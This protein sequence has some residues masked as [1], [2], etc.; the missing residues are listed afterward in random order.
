MNWK[1]LFSFQ[2]GTPDAIS[3]ASFISMLAGILISICAAVSH[4]FFGTVIASEISLAQILLGAG[5][6]AHGA[7]SFSQG[8]GL[9]RMQ[10]PILNNTLVNTGTVQPGQ[11]KPKIVE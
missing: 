2:P 1:Q 10:P 7:S 9:N 6:I 11:P 4:L 3:V 8:Y 5:A